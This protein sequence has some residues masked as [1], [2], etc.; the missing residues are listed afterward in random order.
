MGPGGG[1]MAQGLAQA[2]VRDVEL[3]LGAFDR[4]SQVPLTPSEVVELMKSGSRN[5]QGPKQIAT[6]RFDPYPP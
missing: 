2:V 6:G 5:G 4:S 3:C 1:M